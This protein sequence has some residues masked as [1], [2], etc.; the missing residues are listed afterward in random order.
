MEPMLASPHKKLP[1]KFP[2]LASPKLDGIRAW[3]VEGD[4]LLSRRMKDF[5]N[6]EL[7][8]YLFDTEEE[9]YSTKGL[10]GELCVGPTTATDLM[11]VTTSAIMSHEGDLDGLVWWIFDDFTNPDAPAHERLSRVAER[12]AALNN[13]NIKIVPQILVHSEEELLALEQKWLKEGYEGVMVRDPNSPYKFGRATER[14]GYLLKIKRFADS[15]AEI[16]GFVELNRNLNEATISETGHTKRSTK[17]EGKVGGG[18]LGA[19]Q[20][21]DLVTGIEFEIG[22]GFDAQ[23][24]QDLWNAQGNTLGA[25]V[26]YKYF[27]VGVKDKPR[28]PIFLGFRNIEVD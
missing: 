8:M 6:M 16:I 21:R 12:V 22:S 4:G 9:M 1:L 15:E 23:M 7:H 11:R 5:P 25:T 28:F 24:R 26:K 19:L 20:V 27:A 3:N 18:T 14:E 13:P 10:D 17:K 2:L